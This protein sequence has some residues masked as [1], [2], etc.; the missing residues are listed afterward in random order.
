[1]KLLIIATTLLVAV[2]YAL[3][4]C[5]NGCNGNGECGVGDICTCFKEKVFVN[6]KGSTEKLQAAWTGADCS[7]KTCPRGI[8]WNRHGQEGEGKTIN[9]KICT[10]LKDVECSD[11]GICNR[12][13]G[14]CACFAGYEGAACERTTCPNACS[15]HGTCQSNI[16]FAEDAT[17]Q[18]QPFHAAKLGDAAVFQYLVSYDDAWDSGMH[19]GCKCD[20]G[21]RGPDCSLKECPTGDD[22]ID[23]NCE[24]KMTFEFIDSDIYFSNYKMGLTHSNMK[25]LGNKIHLFN[26]KYTRSN[27]LHQPS[28]TA[29]TEWDEAG[30]NIDDYVEA[31]EEAGKHDHWEYSGYV[32]DCTLG[33]DGAEFYTGM[34]DGVVY[35]YYKDDSGNPVFNQVNTVEEVYEADAT[36][37]GYTFDDD[38]PSQVKSKL[39]KGDYEKSYKRCVKVETCG[40]RTS[41]QTCSGRG[42]CNYGTGQCK[43]YQGYSGNDCSEIE[44]TS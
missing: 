30:G 15:G 5:P 26:D 42:T 11:V 3:G 24:E 39:L 17:V 20:I 21:Y 10:H 28:D 1:M 37:S 2:H 8:S 36:N 22:P 14:E 6:E 4:A 41:S 13:L 35:P 43:C 16:K 40:G 33:G 9:G 44:R 32:G 7:Q 34:K 25:P 29:V 23:P 31:L 38:T 27:L 19:F 12:A 18:L